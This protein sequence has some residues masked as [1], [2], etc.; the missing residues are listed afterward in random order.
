M[1]W[2]TKSLV[3]RVCAAL[4]VLREPVYYGIQRAF[5]RLRLKSDP[6]WLL[7]ES[8]RLAVCLRDAG[9]P[10][11][12]ARVMEVGT[13]RAL[14]MPLGLFLCGAAS[15]RTY[16]LHRY[17]KTHRVLESVAWI[18]THRSAVMQI[19]ETVTDP[20]ALTDR[21]DALCGSR[22]FANVLRTA[23]IEYL[24]PAD[25]AATQLPP[26]SIDIQISYTVFEHIPR[27]I[28][29]AILKEAGRILS[30]GGFAL[31]H[32]DLSDHFAHDDPTISYINFLRF[33][34]AEWEKY[35]ANQ[36]AYH[37][38]LRG[39]EYEELFHE[40]GHKLEQWRVNLDQRSLK[41]LSNGFPLH[42]DFRGFPPE[43]LCG[44]VVHSLS[45]RA[46]ATLG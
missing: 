24:A 42:E 32:I 6:S 19:F 13:G 41:E 34:R 45:R 7:S 11:D 29:V 28:L 31:H 16:D 4:P 38:R 2:Q 35:G 21:L 18:R 43:V 46:S 5:G 25:A 8:A 27:D 44:T 40:A 9:M 14:D 22:D 3:Q 15:I 10:V 36:F 33:S 1:N 17:L 23:H 39:P 12:G 37:N 20:N 30:P 26:N